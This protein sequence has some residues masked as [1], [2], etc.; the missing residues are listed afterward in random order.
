MTANG[1]AGARTHTGAR[2]RAAA[3]KCITCGC[4]SI[5]PVM[6]IMGTLGAMCYACGKPRPV[7]E[8]DRDG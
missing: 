4:R 7:M 2:D 6:N 1:P 3:Y 8:A 5:G